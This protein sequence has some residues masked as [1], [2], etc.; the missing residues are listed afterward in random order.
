MRINSS[1]LASRVSNCRSGNCR[2]LRRGACVAG[3][4]STPAFVQFKPR[5]HNQPSVS[6]LT[7]N[8]LTY[9]GICDRSEPCAVDRLHKRE[10][11]GSWPEK[12]VLTTAA[13]LC[14]ASRASQDPFR[15]HLYQSKHQSR[16]VQAQDC[17][18]CLLALL[19]PMIADEHPVA[20]GLYAAFGWDA[21]RRWH[22]PR[23]EPSVQNSA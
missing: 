19:G 17:A 20:N 9:M 5:K 13:L 23:Q 11:D 4:Q 18:R 1:Y 8:E 7:M 2:R 16:V 10:R 15:A 6:R 3:T 22:R 12:L 14:R 21:K